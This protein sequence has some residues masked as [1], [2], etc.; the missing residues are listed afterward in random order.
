MKSNIVDDFIEAILKTD[1]AAMPPSARRAAR[2]AIVDAYAA[3]LAGEEAPGVRES[4]EIATGETGSDI[5]LSK[6]FLKDDHVTSAWIVGVMARARDV[7]DVHDATGDHPGI[8]AVIGAIE[9]A[10]ISGT[11]TVAEVIAAVAISVDVVLRLRSASR[12]TPDKTPWTTGTYAP[13][14]AAIAAAKVLKFGDEDIGNAIGIAFTFMSNTRQC[15]REGALIHRIH[16]GHATSRGVLSALLARKGV[17]GPRDWI[18]GEWGY[19]Y[20]FH[21]EPEVREEAFEGMGERFRG[22]EVRIKIFT[23]CAHNHFTI[24]NM[25]D[26]RTEN[27]IP[28]SS[29]ERIDV[30]I[31][32]RGYKSVC[33]PLSRRC[34]PDSP[35][36]AQWSLPY[37]AATALV[38]GDVFIKHFD[39][40]AIADPEVLRLAAKVHPIIS[41]DLD[42]PDETISPTKVKVT[43]NDGSTL[44]SALEHLKGSPMRPLTEDDLFEKLTKCH[45]YGSGAVTH[46]DLNAFF[47][48]Y[49]SEAGKNKAAAFLF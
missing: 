22:E 45:A 2:F 19:L 21:H 23:C 36:C 34:A 42:D 3:I 14:G 26:L 38:H 11:A 7:D 30:L 24:A 5:R 20:A 18:L 44:E 8:G 41:E 16:H 13:L 25:L 40:E 37:T 10:K 17:T 35:V 12:E 49:M 33:E 46:D 43:L 32:S 48:A 39:A 1:Y 29:V 27:D 15:S 9:A 4:Y 31:N 6:G 28:P 47:D